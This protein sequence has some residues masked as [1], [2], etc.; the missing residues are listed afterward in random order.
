MRQVQQKFL[1]IIKLKL[2]KHGGSEHVSVRSMSYCGGCLFVAKRVI[3]GDKDV[4][5]E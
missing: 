5:V 1:L 3:L 4:E 2:K